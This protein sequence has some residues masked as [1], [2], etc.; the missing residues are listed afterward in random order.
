M[1][2]A[3]PSTAA[4]SSLMRSASPY[5]DGTGANRR[6]ARPRAL[7]FLRELRLEEL[8][9]PTERAELQ[10]ADGAL[11][12]PEDLRDLTARE[13]LDETQDDD[14]LLLGR[15]V[16][17]RAAERIDGLAVDRALVSGRP[18]F[19]DPERV[20]EV[21]GRTIAA[22]TIGHGVARDRVEPGEERLSLPPIAVDVRECPRED[23]ARQVLGIRGLAHAVEQV[24]VDGIDVLVVE[25]GEGA[26]IAAPGALDDVRDRPE[27]LDR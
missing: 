2:F 7:A 5:I 26:A 12:L 17:D 23:L 6:G 15:E 19:H 27:D 4:R 14:L 1:D 3:M 20:I 11:V 18:L 21:H 16:L 25:L 13:V 8:T 10:R 22:A 9:K 24:S